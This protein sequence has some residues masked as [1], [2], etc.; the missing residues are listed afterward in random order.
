MKRGPKV[1]RA[2]ALARELGLQFRT[3]STRDAKW[4]RFF[5]VAPNANEP[6]PKGGVDG[7]PLDVSAELHKK[8]LSSEA[9]QHI[10]AITQWRERVQPW[11]FD[12]QPPGEQGIIVAAE[13]SIANRFRV[14]SAN[15][16]N[17]KALRKWN[18]PDALA[19][20]AALAQPTPDMAL[21]ALKG[22][23]DMYGVKKPE[24]ETLKLKAALE[25]GAA[26]VALDGT[27]TMGGMQ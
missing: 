4:L 6:M 1:P 10:A 24:A 8:R 9:Q 5:F 16:A 26:I 13:L 3:E 19:R 11:L 27:P 15:R 14:W 12:P 23:L 7:Q 2:E 21:N 22:T 20:R 18:S 17:Q 25:K